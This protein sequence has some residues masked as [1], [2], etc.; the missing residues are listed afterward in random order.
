MDDPRGVGARSLKSA[1]LFAVAAL[2]AVSLNVLFRNP[3]TGAVDL[4]RDSVTSLSSSTTD[5]LASLNA[6][7][8]I[9]YYVTEK[10][11]MPTALRSL[12]RDVRALVRQMGRWAPGRITLE[13]VHPEDRPQEVRSVGRFR[14]S[15]FQHK[16]ILKDEHRVSTVWSGLLVEFKGVSRAV[17]YV[18][19]DHLPHLE[20]RLVTYLQQIDSRYVPTV[21]VRSAG[22]HRQLTA[23]LEMVNL[24]GAGEWVPGQAGPASADAAILIQPENLSAVEVDSVDRFLRDGKDVFVFFSP[25]RILVEGD[26]V[27]VVPVQSGLES[28]LARR[29]AVF[30]PKLL[31]QTSKGGGRPSDLILPASLAN[32]EGFVLTAQGS[33]FFPQAAPVSFDPV[34]G[35]EAGF[36]S[37][38]LLI[39]D[40]QS[41]TRSLAPQGG[42]LFLKSDLAVPGDR[43]SQSENVGMVI[44]SDKP[45]E[46]KL[47]LFSS[48]ALIDD[49]VIQ[50]YSANGLYLKNLLMTFAN[51][52]RM[53]SIQSSRKDKP[54]LPP[55]SRRQ[56]VFWRFV[57]MGVVPLMFAVGWF[58]RGWSW[59]W[60]QS[61]ERIWLGFLRQWVGPVLGV[62]ILLYS[63]PFMG[64]YGV[65]LTREKVNR[66]SPLTLEWAARVDRDIRVTYFRSPDDELPG[67]LKPLGRK[68]QNLLD[69]LASANR[70]RVS[71]RTVLV[72]AVPRPDLKSELD[73]YKLVPFTVRAIEEDRYIEKK[74][75]SA[76]VFET[77]DRAEVIPRLSLSN[78][79]RLEFLCAG[80]FARLGGMVR[81][82]VGVLV[83]LPRLTP[84]EFWELEQLNIKTMP[85]SED[86]YA[87]LIDSLRNEGYSVRLYDSKTE[88]P[89]DEDVLIYIQP[90]VMAPAVRETL[91]RRLAE[92]GN[93]IIAV[94]HYRMQ[95][96]KYPGHAY[97]MVYWPQPQFSRINEFLEPY[98]VELVSE[99][100]LDQSKAPV[101]SR[102]QINWGAY[103]KEEKRAPDAQPFLIRAVPENFSKESPVTARLSDLLFIWGN[104][105]RK[106]PGRFPD[107][108]EWKTL[109]ASS[110][111]AWSLD[112]KGGFLSPDSLRE[113]DYFDSSQPLVVE[114]TGHFPLG[115]V[116]A[117]LPHPLLRSTF[118][119]EG[120][121]NNEFPSPLGRPVAELPAPG[122]AE[123]LRRGQGEGP[124]LLPAKKE[125]HDPVEKGPGGFVENGPNGP[126]SLVL[127]G[128]SEILSNENLDN[129]GFDNGKFFLN[130]VATLAYGPDLAWVQARGGK[131]GSGF[132]FVPPNQ[133]LFWRLFVVGTGPLVFL[134]ARVRRRQP[135]RKA[136]ASSGIRM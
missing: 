2:G 136:Y 46:G 21:A 51:P 41:W 11:R 45:W 70:A 10:R 110:K 131:G 50:R 33:L 75:Y 25:Y 57:G 19:P 114:L 108:L 69:R 3:E 28:W 98:G 126:G 66:L 65:D 89:G 111:D 73:R 59:R 96:R 26:R 9:T 113:G 119:Q 6:P 35:K 129:V 86:V 63:V 32:L 115:K 100:F 116:P 103:R 54:L 71:A 42:T 123:P 90:W 112:W 31:L 36:F 97:S 20:N 128:C 52:E 29:G 85:K 17:P 105:W 39:S 122:A 22:E 109:V 37:R 16:T 125:N 7:V 76:L 132:P 106:F 40:G 92:G 72:P 15:S 133:K 84:G 82:R 91:A 102:E 53:A 81:P 78:L 99:V 134:L 61:N 30:E 68:T 43:P 60:M 24:G 79:D 74:V 44:T 8:K 64:F 56:R 1:V 58:R 127:V 48:G 12:E 62:S 67:P 49:A 13:V 124:G 27:G 117:Q 104:R 18:T 120:K 95:A 94:Q 55:L 38:T 34:K 83:D 88:V 130:A 135:L 93:V 121:E 87:R 14:L 4:A 107:G 77:A 23:T 80:A 5:Y 118:P 101:A 47:F